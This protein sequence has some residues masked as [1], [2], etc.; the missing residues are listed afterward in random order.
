[1]FYL[2]ALALLLRFVLLNQSLW[3]DEAIQALALMGKMG[4]LLTYA[5]ADFQPPLYHGLLWL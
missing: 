5:L 1:M 2:L 4:P 3:L